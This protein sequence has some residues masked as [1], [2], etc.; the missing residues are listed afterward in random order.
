MNREYVN[1]N[2]NS[3]QCNKEKERSITNENNNIKEQPTKV[4][5]FD[6]HKTTEHNHQHQP[7]INNII[8]IMEFITGMEYNQQ[9]FN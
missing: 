3:K 5:V 1:Y 7:Q 9:Q 2:D 6:K 4:P 8:Q